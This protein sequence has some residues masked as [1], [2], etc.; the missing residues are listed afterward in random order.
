MILPVWIH[1]KNDPDRRVKVYAVLGEKSDTC[2]VTDDVIDKLGVTGPVIQLELDTMHAI[3]KIDTQRIDDLVVSR[4]NGKVNIPLPKACTRT[5]IPR[6]CGQIPRPETARK[7]DHL[8][9]IAG[10][11]PPYEEHLSIGLLIGLKTK[12]NTSW[13]VKRHL[14]HTHDVGLGSSRSQKSKKL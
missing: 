9:K 2:F 5:H 14:R 1:H 12:I 8:E 3:E 13:K 4:F 7:Y 10:E 6:Q 11:I